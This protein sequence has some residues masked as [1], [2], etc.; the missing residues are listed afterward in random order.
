MTLISD[1]LPIY[2]GCKWRIQDLKSVGANYYFL[3]ML[4]YVVVIITPVFVDYKYDI[5]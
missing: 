5:L 2:D 1:K 3:N 4:R